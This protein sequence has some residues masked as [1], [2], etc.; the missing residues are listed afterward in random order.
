MTVRTRRVWRA[1]PGSLAIVAVFMAVSA[2]GVPYLGYLV[3]LREGTWPIPAFLGALT[4]VALLYAWR[5][6]LHPKLRAT[7][8]GVVVVNPWRRTTIAWDEITVIAPGENGVVVG[9]EDL[10]AEAWC[11]Q[12][13]NYATRRGTRTRADRIVD[14]LFDLWEK[15]D[16]PLE[17]DETGLRIRRARP[18]DADLLTRLERSS[19][20]ANLGHIFPARRYRYPVSEV[21]RRWRR[22]L[23]NREV[24]VRILELFDTPIGF[25]AYK[26]AGQVLHLAIAPH[27]TRRGYGSVLLEFACEEIFDHGTREAELWVLTENHKARAFYRSHG[28][29]ETEDRGKSDFPPYPEELRMT[30][31]NP[32]APRR[33]S[34]D[35]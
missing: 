8:R 9:S 12:K 6:G 17:D 1:A 30:R 24:Q 25:V 16:P 19:S 31:A 23:R 7:D 28:W 2:L 10:V 26:P 27:Q 15:H 34:A 5:F 18:S 14:E 20:E 29:R 21:S 4:V 13:S 22:L 32:A 3:Y 35:R 33:R 11:I